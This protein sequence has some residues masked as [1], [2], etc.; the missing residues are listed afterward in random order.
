[1]DVLGAREGKFVQKYG[2]NG[3]WNPADDLCNEVSV[4][5]KEGNEYA[6]SGKLYSTIKCPNCGSYELARLLWG[7][8]AVNE[9]LAKDIAD[10]KIILAGCLLGSKMPR[11]SCKKCGNNIN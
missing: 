9:E 5:I 4:T 3:K 2:K 1:M 11:Y 6:L 7:M 10:G 8:P